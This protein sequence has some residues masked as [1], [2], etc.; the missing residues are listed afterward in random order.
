MSQLPEA[1]YIQLGTQNG[2]IH[3]VMLMVILNNGLLCCK[4]MMRIDGILAS[5]PLIT[6][7]NTYQWTTLS[8]HGDIDY[9]S[10]ITFLE[11]L[12]NELE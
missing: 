7:L 10:Q 3:M 11:F 4:N 6:M 2:V 1:Y 12:S 8:I 9:Q 5:T